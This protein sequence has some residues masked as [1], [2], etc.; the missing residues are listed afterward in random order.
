MRLPA[1][2]LVTL[3][4]C[5]PIAKQP[6]T[7]ALGQPH[8]TILSY[9]VN[10]GLAGDAA[11]LAAIRDAGADVVFLQETTPEWEIV[12]RREL[13]TQL[14]HMHFE[15]CCGA[16][17]LA[18]LSKHPF[19]RDPV[20]NSP[21]GWFP[22]W[23]V[24]VD[25]PLGPVQVL[26]VHLRPPVSDSGSWVSG[27]FSTGHY[28]RA[29]LQAFTDTLA[30]DVPTIVLGDFNE[31]SGDALELLET[32]GLRDAVTEFHP[33]GDTWRWR[34]RFG[35]LSFA[36]DH[37]FYDTALDALDTRILDAG[38]SDHLPILVLFERS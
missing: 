28:R 37:V 19:H 21:I 36:L 26:Q 16:G 27:Y 30:D 1:L 5:S 13:K 18:V 8:M 22:G 31:E 25:T 23:R 34:T 20:V 24:Q 17:G 10:Y 32:R 33:D 9:N 4:A 12:L 11:T 15:H 38:R 29:E 14:P 35:E 6:R 3:V 2:A 7:P